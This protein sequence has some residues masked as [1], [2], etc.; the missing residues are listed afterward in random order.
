VTVAVCIANGPS[1]SPEDVEYC[2]RRAKIYAVKESVTL[3]PW[4]DVLYAADTDWWE[5][6]QGYPAFAGEKWTVSAEA[7]KKWGINTLQYESGLAWSTI[8]GLLATGGN[9]G[10]QALN[11]AV[12]QGASQVLLLGFDMG[13]AAGKP[14]HWWTGQITRESRT[15]N[16][17][18]WIKKFRNAA[19]L[20]PVPVVNVSRETRLDC[21]PR[22]ELRD[23]L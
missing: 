1:L 16:Y 3:C 12:L 11:L 9:S 21:F 7:G 10:F 23:V 20:I 14:K 18:E 4:A 2:R 6:Y 5:R 22:A 17:D 8:P 13:H 19:P 15:S